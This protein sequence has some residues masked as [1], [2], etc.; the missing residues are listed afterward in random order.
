MDR[1]LAWIAIAAV[2][3]SVGTIAT[4]AH[5]CFGEAV[6]NQGS[7]HGFTIGEDKAATYQ[8]LLQL[9]QN[10][11]I[12]GF[13]GLDE[14]PESVPR[15]YH[16]LATSQPAEMSRLTLYDS[17]RLVGAEGRAL[18]V[19]RF[20]RGQVS[21]IDVYD[22]RG[23]LLNHAT[24]WTTSPASGTILTGMS[25][26]DAMQV[27]EKH[28]SNGLLKSIES[29]EHDVAPPVTFDQ[30]SYVAMEPWDVWQL[31]VSDYGGFWL[32]FKHGRLAKIQRK[33]QCIELP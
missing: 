8:R 18:G 1:K 28:L 27:V 33:V 20:R 17:W 16:W 6:V 15:H 26:N 32:T 13:W 4:W 12:Q 25:P 10:K 2:L 21:H 7:S 14:N 9:Q 29:S 23:Y 31:G 11:T 3:V 24:E 19:V 30:S 22:G 5:G